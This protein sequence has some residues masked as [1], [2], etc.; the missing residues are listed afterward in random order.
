MI[1][2]EQIQQTQNLEVKGKIG[3]VNKTKVPNKKVDIQNFQ[4][5]L[6]VKQAHFSSREKNTKIIKGKRKRPL[7]ESKG[8][9]LIMT[10]AN[11]RKI[12]KL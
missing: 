12:T 3:K 10:L 7:R 1:N 2:K 6:I 11:C 8:T 9:V 5:K 4:Q